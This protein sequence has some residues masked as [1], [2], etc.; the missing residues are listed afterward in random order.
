MHLGSDHRNDIFKMGSHVLFEVFFEF[1]DSCGNG[2][3]HVLI[4]G[5]NIGTQLSQSLLGLCEIRLQGI[6]ARFQVL[7]MGLGHDDTA[8]KRGG[9]GQIFF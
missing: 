6:E 9:W 2:G 8:K 7:A 1:N 4:D 3:M 5:G